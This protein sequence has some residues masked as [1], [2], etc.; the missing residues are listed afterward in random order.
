[1]KKAGWMMLFMISVAA[2]SGTIEENNA[3]TASE[4]FTGTF[5]NE[6]NKYTNGDVDTYT[7]STYMATTFF[8]SNDHLITLTCYTNS[9][10]NWQHTVPYY[11]DYTLKRLV[12]SNCSG[13]PSNT[14]YAT[15]EITGLNSF[16]F[17]REDI[18]RVSQ[19]DDII[20]GDG[21][22]EYGLFTRIAQ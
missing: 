15:Y 10:I 22:L 6:E 17:V 7:L 4:V 5:L 12:I 18:D 9:A 16:K 8:F 1:M 14:M 13:S 2:C 11:F 20:G 19:V 21:V 3:P